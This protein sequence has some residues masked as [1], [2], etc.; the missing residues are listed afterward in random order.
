MDK[1]DEDR[2]YKNQPEWGT[3][4]ATKKAKEKTPGQMKEAERK[5]DSPQ[6]PDIK[7]RPGTQPKAYHAGLSK[8]TKTARDRHFKK[9]AK[10]DD[11]NPKAYKKAPGDAGAKTKPSKH[12]MRFKQMF[13]EEDK[14]GH[15]DRIKNKINREKERDK[16]KH[17]RMMDIARIRDTQAKNKATR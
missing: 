9:G 2:W 6:D 15:V 8:K 11:D 16:Q 4:E 13:G 5:K 12:T 10:M 1:L 17:D 7:D 3:P 14:P